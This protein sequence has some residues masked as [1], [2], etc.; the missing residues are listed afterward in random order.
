LD[1]ILQLNEGAER[2]IVM[3]NAGYSPSPIVLEG[4]N[5]QHAGMQKYIVGF[6]DTGL[7]VDSQVTKSKQQQLFLDAMN[8]R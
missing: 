2:A 7:N 3:V 8:I 5:K 4:I 1:N 6:R